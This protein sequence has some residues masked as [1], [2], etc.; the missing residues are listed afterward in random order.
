MPRNYSIKFILRVCILSKF[1]FIVYDMVAF[2]NNTMKQSNL[3]P[4]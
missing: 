3:I 4:A 2:A 1:Y